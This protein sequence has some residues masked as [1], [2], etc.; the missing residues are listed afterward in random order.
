MHRE[1]LAR[2][3]P[4]HDALG[5]RPTD[6]PVPLDI[7][8]DDHGIG[9]AASS[10]NR[11]TG[12]LTQRYVKRHRLALKSP[13][14]SHLYGSSR[15]HLS[16]RFRDGFFGGGMPTCLNGAAAPVALRTFA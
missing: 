16:L 2:R 11:L 15:P 13:E 3:H 8:V 7:S 14:I 9:A 1:G 5:K 4:H 12:S 10:I 6:R